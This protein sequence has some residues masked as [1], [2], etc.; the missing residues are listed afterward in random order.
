M[1]QERRKM[2]MISTANRISPEES[3]SSMMRNFTRLV[4]NNFR[5]LLF[6]GIF[7]KGG[8]QPIILIHM[9]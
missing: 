1:L 9:P 8:G 5:V 7:K 4:G 2:D 6:F 3:N